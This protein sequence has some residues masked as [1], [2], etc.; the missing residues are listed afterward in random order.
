MLRIR[1]RVNT[2]RAGNW[3]REELSGF[4]SSPW[5]RM[6]TGVSLGLITKNKRKNTQ[7]CSTPVGTK[8]HVL[9]SRMCTT[10]VH[11]ELMVL[12]VARLMI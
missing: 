5:R 6:S 10:A 4:G 8:G 7:Q 3:E 11:R 1:R 12:Q 9:A 2:Q